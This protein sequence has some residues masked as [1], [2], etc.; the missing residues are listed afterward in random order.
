MRIRLALWLP[1]FVCACLPAT[2][3]L[4]QVQA[5]GYLAETAAARQEVIQAETVTIQKLNLGEARLGKNRFSAAVRNNTESYVTLLVDLRA[6]PGLWLR[7]WQRQLLFLLTPREEKEIEA[8]YKF[9]RLSPEGWLR[10]G[11]A[12]PQVK[13]HGVTDV[14]SFFFQKKYHVGWGNKAVDYKVSQ[15]FEERQTKRFRIYYLPHSLAASDMSTIV[16]QRESAFRRISDMLGVGYREPI[17]L[18]LFPDAEVK[19]RETGHTGDGFAFGNIMGE[20]YSEKTKLDPYHELTHILA[21]QLGDP[22]AMFNEGFAVYVSELMR[23]D[24]LKFLGSPG[25]KVDDVVAAQ[26]KE[27]KLI[28]LEGL[29]A[30]TEIGSEESRS[31][32]SYPEAASFVKFLIEKYG[33]DKFRL[34]YKSLENSS[35]AE[36]IRKNKQAYREICGK[37]PSEMEPE[38][39]RSLPIGKN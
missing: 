38:W 9:L 13:S 5:G 16:E 29:F 3:C 24:A 7:K 25:K 28:P 18:F 37:L 11:F 27:G 30:F 1:I 26:R 14:P 36:V 12:F 8:E 21:G 22:P 33:L 39:L 20:I 23:T 15:R 32:T 17:R 31:T 35:G 6:D 2:R 4:S 10:V 34:A 19:K